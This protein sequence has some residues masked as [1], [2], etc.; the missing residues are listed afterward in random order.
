[1]LQHW[2]DYEDVPN[3]L[4]DRILTGVI[5]VISVI[6]RVTQFAMQVWYGV[7]LVFT[8]LRS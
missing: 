7:H 2:T 8:F 3:T 6:G 1:M 4:S 5:V